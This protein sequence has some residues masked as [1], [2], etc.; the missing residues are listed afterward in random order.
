MEPVA[1]IRV[2][3]AVSREPTTGGR[4]PDAGSRGREPS[5]GGREP[6]A[7]SRVLGAES[8]EPKVGVR[9]AGSRE[10]GAE[11]V[12]LRSSDIISINQRLL[13]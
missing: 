12:T 4:E 3:V 7:E 6:G 5:P 8:R 11:D 10:L 13:P 1:E 2:P 9:V